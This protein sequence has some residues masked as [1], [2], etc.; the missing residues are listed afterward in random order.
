MVGALK[1]MSS[2][3]CHWSCTDLPRAARDHR[4]QGPPRGFGL[5]HQEARQR[6]EGTA[7]PPHRG[8]PFPPI[9]QCTT[10]CRVLSSPVA[11][12]VGFLHPHRIHGLPRFPMRQSHPTVHRQQFSGAPTPAPHRAACPLCLQ[13]EGLADVPR[14]PGRHP[15]PLLRPLHR[16]ARGRGPLGTHR[17]QPL[18][19]GCPLAKAVCSNLA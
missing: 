1:H 7:P 18:P 12:F 17:R 19:T 5:R 9:S 4:G 15:H 10:V 8:S 11:P 2:G 16:L 6:P 13:P 14:H 3:P